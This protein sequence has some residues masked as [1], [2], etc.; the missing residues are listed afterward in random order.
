M[1][2][3]EHDNRDIPL[4]Y[5]QWGMEDEDLIVGDEGADVGGHRL[6]VFSA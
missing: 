3:K 6:G 2:Q 4:R 5:A 1:M